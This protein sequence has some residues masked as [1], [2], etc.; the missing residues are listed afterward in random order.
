MIFV[1]QQ[2]EEI[3]KEF[4]LL[5]GWLLDNPK[6]TLSQ[7]WAKSKYV[8][9]GDHEFDHKEENDDKDRPS[10]YHKSCTAMTPGEKEFMPKSAEIFIEL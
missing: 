5:F 7:G 6:V 4:L 1:C 3:W 9:V 2:I 8:N 10:K